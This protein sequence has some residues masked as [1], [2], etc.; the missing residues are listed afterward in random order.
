M[1][2]SATGFEQVGHLQTRAPRRTWSYTTGALEGPAVYV[3][4]M[5]S[6]RDLTDRAI[7]VAT[8]P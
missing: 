5:R 8:A 2:R 1:N 6:H 4:R 3:F 7:V